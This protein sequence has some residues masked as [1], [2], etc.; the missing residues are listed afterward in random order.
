[1]SEAFPY[2]GAIVLAIVFAFHGGDSRFKR[3]SLLL[4]L[5]WGAVM[6]A[7]GVLGSTAL[8]M[9]WLSDAWEAALT[10]RGLLGKTPW[11]VWLGIDAVTLCFVIKPPAGKVQAVIAGLLGG[12]VLWHAAFGY[13]A[14][15]LAAGLYKTALNAGGWVQVGTLIVGAGYDQGRRVVTACSR[16]VFRSASAAYDLARVDLKP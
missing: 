14:D 3:T 10:A 13:V 11:L 6:A 2:V 7:R 5:N 12:Q 8:W 4:L 16:L 9:P 1:M 15:P